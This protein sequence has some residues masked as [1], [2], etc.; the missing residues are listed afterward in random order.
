[1][2]I[3]KKLNLEPIQGL[4]KSRGKRISENE[5]SINWK[6]E[7]TF[8]EHYISLGSNKDYATK[9][10]TISIAQ[11]DGDEL[12]IGFDDS[13]SG[14]RSRVNRL[15]SSESVSIC[16]K[17]IAKEIMTFLRFPVDIKEK[18][19]VSFEVVHNSKDGVVIKILK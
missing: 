9:F 12:Y 18:Y 1:M 10:R 6:P 5:I 4:A 17:K 8:S 2:S 13:T 15:G 11:K 3:L 16:N 19:I 7:G 14:L